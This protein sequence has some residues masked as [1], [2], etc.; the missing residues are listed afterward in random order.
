MLT[1]STQ[2]E[3]FQFHKSSYLTRKLRKRELRKLRYLTKSL[4]LDTK[5]IKGTGKKYFLKRFKKPLIKINYMKLKI[6]VN[7]MT[8]INQTI[9]MKTK[10]INQANLDNISKISFCQRW[11]RALRP[12]A[13][14]FNQDHLFDYYITKEL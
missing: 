6:I 3:S 10:I 13:N 9:V 2:V 12:I 4:I 7:I 8:L 5:R 14:A 1:Q 11:T